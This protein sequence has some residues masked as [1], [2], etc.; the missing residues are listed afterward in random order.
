MNRRLIGVA[1]VLVVALA[2]WGV[3]LLLRPDGESLQLYG[4]IDIR[5][6]AIGFEIPGRVEALA[7]DE[8]ARVAAGQ[9]LGRLDADSVDAELAEAQGTL[10]AA[11]ARLALLRAGPTRATIAQSAA[12]VEERRA[13]LADVQA[14]L[15]RLAP[16]VGTG[17]VADRDVENARSRVAE[18]AARLRQAEQALADVRAGSRREEIAQAE[19]E[20]E[21]ARATVERLRIRTGDA[22]LVAPESGVVLTRAVEVGE[23]VQGGQTAFTLALTDPV[24]ARIYVDAKDLGRVAPGAE[25]ELTTDA[26]PGHVYRGRVGHVSPTAEFTPRAVES[27]ELR[28]DLVYRA[29]VVVLNPDD[30]LR[31]GMPIT[32]RFPH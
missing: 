8:G 12:Q 6:A 27:P 13:A 3:W 11:E 26:A 10:S 9:E 28:T 25:V 20:R 5:E 23:V 16:L 31:Q 21:R 30:R 4:N 1:A 29:R 2:G 17:A 15:N 18:A 14:D 19:A 22:V 7:V 24:W 32:V